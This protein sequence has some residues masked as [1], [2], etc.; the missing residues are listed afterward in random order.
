MS[1]WNIFGGRGKEAEQ[2]NENVPPFGSGTVDMTTL[3]ITYITHRLL[4]EWRGLTT[5]TQLL[6]CTL[7][8]INRWLPSPFQN[9]CIV[10]PTACSSASFFAC[11]VASRD[12]HASRR[13]ASC[14]TR[15]G[16]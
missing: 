2:E 4:G 15:P 7:H 13:F 1:L 16:L 6:V 12:V 11:A 8:Q 5:K 3:D 14:G 10:V 9:S